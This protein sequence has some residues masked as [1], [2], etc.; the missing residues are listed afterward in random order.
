[1]AR[2]FALRL[3]PLHE[4]DAEAMIAETRAA[5]LLG[6]YRRRP[7]ADVASLAVCLYALA[8]F[9]LIEGERDRGNR[10][11]P[12]QGAGRG[13]RLQNR[14][15]ADRGDITW[16]GAN[17]VSDA[18]VLYKAN[19]AV[20]IITLNRPEK[21]NPI[22]KELRAGLTEAF[23][24]ADDDP[25]THVVVLRAEGRSFC[26]GYDISS[27]EADK[28]SWRHDTLKWH[29]HLAKSLE[30]EMTPWYMRKPVIASVQ[31]HALGGGCEL[32][33]F[34]DLTIA[35][36]NAL[37]GE[38]EIRF[39]NVGPAIVMPWIIGYKK[40][41]ELLYLGDM[42]DA[43]TALALG[44]VNRVVPLHEL[45]AATLQFARR[46]AL[47]SPR[48][49]MRPSCRSIAA[50]TSPGFAV[51]CRPAWIWRR[52]SMRQRQRW[53]CSSSTLPAST[54]S[55]PPCGGAG[56][57]SRRSSEGSKIAP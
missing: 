19:D 17:A 40:A 1:M 21:L 37:F 51:P 20:G 14:R 50:P 11:Q 23:R 27:G 31:G 3:L 36:D 42:I 7:A 6:A 32:T 56:R 13:K 52:R 49:C 34:C 57:N 22:S 47:I 25:A 2:D 45:K 15:R 43:G 35:A 55:E 39:S 16:T 44:M 54:G 48:R 46:L 12:D 10:P 5:A 30:F 28:E 41:R 53:A 9:A 4:G 29:A 33:M 26:A 24:R 18:A 38:P 8:D